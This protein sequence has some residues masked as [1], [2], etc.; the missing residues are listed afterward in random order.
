MYR[1]KWWTALPGGFF[2]GQHTEGKREAETPKDCYREEML[3][4][5]SSSWIKRA[6]KLLSL[7]RIERDVNDLKFS[8][9][10]GIT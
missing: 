10:V 9:Y 1:E 6:Y 2:D 7:L 5:N 4:P 8:S 3:N